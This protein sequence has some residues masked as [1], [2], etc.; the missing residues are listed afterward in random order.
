MARLPIVAPA[1]APFGMLGFTFP[2]IVA[3]FAGCVGVTIPALFAV[4]TIGATAA[5][6]AML[7]AEIVAVAVESEVVV[8]ESVGT[9]ELLAAAVDVVVAL[10]VF[11]ERFG[12][13]LLSTKYALPL[14]LMA[15]PSDT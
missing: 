10:Q 7:A 5:V 1:M 13:S 9:V 11:A 2:A 8:A 4:L 15:P 6:V 14:P 3:A 12:S